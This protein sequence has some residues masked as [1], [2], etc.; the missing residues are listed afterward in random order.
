[1][2]TQTQHNKAACIR[3]KHCLIRTAVKQ[4]THLPHV[5]QD[6]HDCRACLHVAVYLIPAS[7]CRHRLVTQ[8]IQ[9]LKGSHLH[10]V[11]TYTP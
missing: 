6:W 7:H 8:T 9:Q 10:G 2:I 3:V 5:S 4:I 11:T 1:M